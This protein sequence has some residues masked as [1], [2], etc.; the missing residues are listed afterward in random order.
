MPNMRTYELVIRASV[1]QGL[2]ECAE[3]L[4]TAAETQGLPFHG[5]VWQC[6]EGSPGNAFVLKWAPK[7]LEA[8]WQVPARCF[9]ILFRDRAAVGGMK[10]AVAL[11]K[12][13][14]RVKSDED[15]AAQALVQAIA[16]IQQLGKLSDVMQQMQCASHRVNELIRKLPQ[17]MTSQVS[18]ALPAMLPAVVP[19]AL[20]AAMPL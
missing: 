11:Y 6:L 8:G 5:L 12:L 14:L 9:I 7:V 2:Y 1:Q 16:E 4:L 19:A 20:P 13:L 17:K 10:L 3:M 15:K 18:S